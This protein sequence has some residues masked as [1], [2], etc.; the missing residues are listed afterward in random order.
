MTDDT[1]LPPGS[2]ADGD[3]PRPADGAVATTDVPDATAGRRRFH[4][5]DA[6]ARVIMVVL[7][8]GALFG[9]VLTVKNATT[10]NDATSESKPD[11]VDRL[12]PASGSEVLRQAAVGVDVAAGY[13]AYLIINGTTVRS[14][15]DGLS[16]DLGTGLIQYT[17]GPGRPV[18]ELNAE[19]NCVLAMVWKQAEGEKTAKPVS[20]CFTAS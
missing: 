3:P 10:G 9:L 16:K 1:P 11:Y 17:P 15:K 20:W 7:V 18:E 14:P 13:D 12:I 5:S 6:W 19:K 2:G 8:L 4:L